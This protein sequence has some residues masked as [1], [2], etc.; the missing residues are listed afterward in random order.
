MSVLVAEDDPDSLDVVETVLR[1]C[2]ATVT[3]ATTAREALAR[4]AGAAPTIVVTD[5]SMP[6]E[7][8]FWLLERLRELPHCAT[9][10]V[11]ALTAR[12]GLDERIEQAGFASYVVKPV[13]PWAFC[14][15]LQRVHSSAGTPG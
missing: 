14:S 11:V 4:L 13:D 1:Y 6:D 10:P 9:V 5:I 15:E 12:A 8:G 3:T 7:D 2:G